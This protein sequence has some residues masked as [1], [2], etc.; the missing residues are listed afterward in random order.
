MESIIAGRIS[1]AVEE[2]R[3]L[4]D[5]HLGGRK[6]VSTE[7]VLH[8]LPERIHATWEMS[9]SQV[10]SIL[11]LDVSGGFDHVSHERLLTAYGKDE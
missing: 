8:L 2:H 1:Y 3:L 10:A 5:Q 7:Q 4:P 11:F 6:G 9:P